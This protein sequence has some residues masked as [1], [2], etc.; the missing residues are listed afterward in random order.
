[1]VASDSRNPSPPI[2]ESPWLWIACFS[3]MG[4]VALVAVQTKVARREADIEQRYRARQFSIPASSEDVK[5]AEATQAVPPSPAVPRKDG[6]GPGFLAIVLLVLL[7]VSMTALGL[8]RLA[9]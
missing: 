9:P 7:A 1:V 6:L 8:R 2:S 3:A 5:S 4:L